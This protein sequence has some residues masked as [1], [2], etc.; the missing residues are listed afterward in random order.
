[1][2]REKGAGGLYAVNE[3]RLSLNREKHVI[4]VGQK[5][6]INQAIK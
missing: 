4:R 3:G 1:M 6:A 2:T 5:E